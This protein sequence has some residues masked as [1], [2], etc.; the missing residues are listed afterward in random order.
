[1]ESVLIAESDSQKRNQLAGWLRTWGYTV[2]DVS[3]GSA[4]KDAIQNEEPRLLLLG[5]YLD[6]QPG[7]ELLKELRESGWSSD[8]CIIIVFSADQSDEIR[9]VCLSAGADDFIP[10]DTEPVDLSMRVQSGLEIL[11]YRR[12]ITDLNDQLQREKGILLRY[13]PADLVDK[14]LREEIKPELGGEITDATIMFF[15][16]RKS[17]TIAERI[18]AARYA[19]FIS[20]ILSNVM[21]IIFDNHGSVN[22]I[23]G[24][25]ILATFGIPDKRENHRRLALSTASSIREYIRKFNEEKSG[26]FPEEPVGFGIG[27][28]TGR[29]FAGNIGSVR[30]MKYA[31]MG[32]S[33]NRASRIQDL[34]KEVNVPILLEESV[35]PSPWQDHFHRIIYKDKSDRFRFRLESL[36]FYALRGAAE[37]VRIFG[38]I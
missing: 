11:S 16:I 31:V 32:P 13:F 37:P 6:D 9:I 14:I 19:E 21:E 36:G 29:V 34:T 35:L 33:V 27:I 15:D 3:S 28:S 17:T 10:W 12:K 1:M 8:R 30:H 38:I 18:G 20:G 5:L 23:Q 2:T 24:D 4:A 25:G 26:P 7:L 22:E